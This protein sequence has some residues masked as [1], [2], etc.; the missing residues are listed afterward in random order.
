MLTPSIAI[1]LTILAVAVILM[2]SDRLRPD[3]VA[4]LVMTSLGVTGLLTPQEVFSGF[5]RSAVIAIAAIFILTA[6]LFHTGVTRAIGAHLLR[7]AGRREARLVSIIML[8]GALLSLFMNNI[9]AAAML[10]PAVSGISRRSRVSPSRLLMPLAFATVLGG[11]ATLL[12]T[13]NIVVSSLLSAEGLPGFGLLDFAPIGVPVVVAG[14]G[15]MI[16]IGRRLLPERWPMQRMRSLHRELAELY[17]LHDDLA[18]YHVRP[19]SQLVGRSLADSGLGEKMGV[20]VLAIVRNSWHRPWLAP[21]PD[22][23]LRSNDLLVVEGPPAEAAVL[24]T[25]GLTSGP[26]PAAW[27]GELA[28]DVVGLVEAVLSPR[29]SLAGKTLREIHFREKFGLSVVALWREGRPL[30]TGLADLPLHFGDALLLQGTRDRI[31]LLSSEHDFIVLDPEP[32]RPNQEATRPSKAPLAGAIM[33]A[34]LLA[35]GAGLLPV[36]EAMLAG[37]L[38]MVLTG[39]L[40][41]DEAYQ[42]VEWKAVFLIAGML[43]LSVA[44]SKTGTAELLGRWLVRGLGSFGPLVLAAGL[45]SLTMLLT[46]TMAGPAVATIITPIAISAAR[47][48]GADPR[49]FG[50]DVALATSMAFLTPLGHPVNVLVM[51]PGGYRFSDFFKVGWPLSLLL[52]AIILGLLPLFW[53]L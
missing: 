13:T 25:L 5:S 4:L 8:A 2:V 33:L 52:L 29:T 6:G 31:A 41:M 51:G 15:Y 45:F 1:V 32:Y 50:M 35:S 26:A 23:R 12:T 38:L 34:A 37:A 17:H 20:N 24:E 49:A 10:M 7:I 42:A 47:Q 9:A 18:E 19:D 48:V 43:P 46:Q 22:M 3:L 16:L 14:V 30:R 28:S 27:A 36:A 39:C 21:A 11:M 53:R 44:M 40:T